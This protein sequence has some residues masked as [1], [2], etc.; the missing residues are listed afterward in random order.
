MDDFHQSTAPGVRRA[1]SSP[2]L[3]G[4]LIVLASVLLVPGRAL[5]DP[6]STPSWHAPA[7]VGALLSDDATSEDLPPGDP[8]PADPA[9]DTSEPAPAPSESAPAEPAPSDPVPAPSD[10]APAP[11][12]PAPAPSEPAPAPAEPAPA[13]PAPTDPV[14]PAEEVPV[15]PAPA[16]SE[17]APADPAPRDGRTTPKPPAS[18]E[19]QLPAG[20]EAAVAPVAAAPA[21]APS[22]PIDADAAD[23]PAKP[24]GDEDAHTQ[25]KAVRAAF[26]RLGLGTIATR[27]PVEDGVSV[28]AVPA[29]AC[30]P[31]GVV[32]AS[33][34]PQVGSGLTTHSTVRTHRAYQ[35]PPV[36][37]GP[38][39]PLQSPSS[40]TATV[41][42]ASAGTGGANG[43]RDCAILADQIA[44][45]LVDGG[46]AGAS[47]CCDHAAPAP[48]N[49]AARA[50]P[51]V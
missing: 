9:A 17:P 14:P 34:A 22:A 10:P 33:D 29:Q 7:V 35:D 6:T 40:P 4:L 31:I 3:L 42:S 19:R 20:G 25:A 50:P 48:A 37:R 5:A 13:E 39:A 49:A 38:P 51:V 16:P 1:T 21:T 41:A 44:F 46:Y 23:E 26:T 32:I 45:T 2:R 28:A 11:S 15:D 36:V 24:A 30:T 27:A 47:D 12:D 18:E 8:F 43:D